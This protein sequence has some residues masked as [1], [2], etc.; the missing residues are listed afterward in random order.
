MF[1]DNRRVKLLTL[2]AMCF[3]LFMAMLDNTVVN[4]ALP[5]I[6]AHFSS[7]VSDPTFAAGN[8]VAAIISFGMFGIFFSF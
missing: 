2:G 8:A 1:A 3:A 6:Q 7:G 4:V 5:K